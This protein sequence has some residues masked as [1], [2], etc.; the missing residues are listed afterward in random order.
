[1]SLLFGKLTQDFV[2][3][4]IIL[5][6]AS[7]GSATAAQEIPIAAEHFRRTS[8]KDVSYLTL[9]G[10]PSHIDFLVLHLD[11]NRRRWN[12]GLHVYVYVDMGIHRRGQCETHS[13]TLPQGHLASRHPIF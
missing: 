13:R 3:F 9:I 4:Q 7:A 12:L 10:L 2:N 1:M 5:G 11:L 6:Q 8:A